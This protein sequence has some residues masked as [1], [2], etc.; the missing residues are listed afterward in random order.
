MATTYKSK[1]YRDNAVFR[2]TDQNG[3][4]EITATVSIP[5][6]KNLGV[7][8]VLKFFRLGSDVRIMQF[9]LEVDKFDTNANVT[10]A[11]KLGITASD[12]C[13]IAAA[14][15]VQT[16]TTGSMNLARVD[17]EATAIDSF[18][19]TPFPA[20]TSTQDVYFTVGVAA[21]TAY[22]TGTRNF[23]LRAK[24]QNVYADTVVVGVSATNY[25]LS[26]SKSTEVAA[27][28]DYNGNAP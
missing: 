24:I 17:G 21:A 19:V 11:G 8:D 12:A 27:Q 2:P 14:T 5:D 10:L 7:G 22:S 28:Y 4:E 3:A 1:V 26:G 9:E 15:E 25:P 23:T 20:Q 13:L 6:G 16:N 18:A